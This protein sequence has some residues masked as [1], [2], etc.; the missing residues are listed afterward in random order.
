MSTTTVS[1]VVA[2]VNDPTLTSLSER[3]A[4][5]QTLLDMHETIRKNHQ[6]AFKRHVKNASASLD[7]GGSPDTLTHMEKGIEIQKLIC[8]ETD[9]MAKYARELVE[10]L[11]ER[12][13]VIRGMMVMDEGEAMAP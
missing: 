7:K 10:L 6:T 9:E 1:K 4:A 11:E 3:I 12:Q 8:D 2:M 5:T 13:K